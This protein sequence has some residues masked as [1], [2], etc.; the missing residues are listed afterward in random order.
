[1]PRSSL[2]A[3]VASL[4]EKLADNTG[5]TRVFVDRLRIPLMV[6]RANNGRCHKPF[7]PGGVPVELQQEWRFRM[8]V[9]K[10]PPPKKRILPIKKMALSAL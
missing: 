3:R 2:F 9:D 7:S 5:G 6:G 1:M 8:S 4:I 10:R